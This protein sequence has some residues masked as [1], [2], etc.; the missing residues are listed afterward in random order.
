M[1]RAFLFFIST[2]GSLQVYEMQP[3]KINNV[4]ES[5]W[6]NLLAT[7]DAKWSIVENINT[8]LSDTESRLLTQEER[9]KIINQLPEWVLSKQDY[10]L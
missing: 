2:G 1:V 3:I 7:Y 6:H 8:H 10:L 4:T 5:I 9:K